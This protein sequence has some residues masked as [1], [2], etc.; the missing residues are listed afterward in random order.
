MRK[1]EQIRQNEFCEWAYEEAMKEYSRTLHYDDCKR[2]RTCTA[3]VYETE[4]WYILRSYGTFVAVIEK[5]TDTLYD[6]LRV[7]YGYTST[8]AQHIVKFS[9]DYGSGKWGVA[10]RLTARQ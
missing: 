3:W 6:V 9:H 2:L 8:S 10:H 4:N 7:T 5:L 1:E